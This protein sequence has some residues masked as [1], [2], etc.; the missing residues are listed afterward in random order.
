MSFKPCPGLSGASGNADDDSL[1]QTMPL[2]WLPR[3]SRVRAMLASRACRSSIMIGDSLSRKEMER[4]SEFTLQLSMISFFSHAFRDK[5]PF[6]FLSS[7][8]R[9][10]LDLHKFSYSFSN[11]RLFT[12]FVT[13]SR[14]GFSLELSSWP[15]NDAPLSGF[16]FSRQTMNTGSIQVH[17]NSVRMCVNEFCLFAYT[18][19]KGCQSCKF[20]RQYSFM[21]EQV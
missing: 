19:M 10:F 21:C 17:F 11:S 2:K 3:P 13:S 16:E 15:T 7:T 8:S 5:M 20:E 1:G 9:S 18:C 6:R 14:V 12:D 4:V